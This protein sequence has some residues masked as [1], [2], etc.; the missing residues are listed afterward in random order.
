MRG[1][2]ILLNK[3]AINDA[4]FG[5]IKRIVNDLNAEWIFYQIDYLTIFQEILS[6]DLVIATKRLKD[7]TNIIIKIVQSFFKKLETN[8]FLLV[9][10]FFRYNDFRQKDLILNN[11]IDELENNDLND[12]LEIEGTQ[13]NQMDEESIKWTQTEDK[14]LIDNYE[15]FKTL[16]NP[17]EMFVSLFGQ[18]SA[19]YRT[20]HEI[21]KRISYLKLARGVDFAQDIF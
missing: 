11:Y 10:S 8:S 18:Q 7:Y 19:N 14:M 21:E 12:V 2:K 1:E 13:K 4:V 5:F 9:E 6:N 17:I 3:A 15:L 20:A 16:D